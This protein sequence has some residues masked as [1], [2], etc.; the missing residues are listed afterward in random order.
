MKITSLVAAAVLIAASLTAQK[1]T[2]R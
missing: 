1:I 2:C